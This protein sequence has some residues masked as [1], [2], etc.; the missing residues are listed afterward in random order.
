MSHPKIEA[1]LNEKE[2]AHYFSNAA[3]LYVLGVGFAYFAYKATSPFAAGLCFWFSVFLLCDSF[4]LARVCGRLERTA[5]LLLTADAGGL[6]HYASWINPERFSWKEITG[7][8]QL[9]TF[10]GETLYFQ[11][12]PRPG[13]LLRYAL[14]GAPKLD[15]PLRSVPGG[16]ESLLG[17]LSGLPEAAHLVPERGPAPGS[18][19]QA[20]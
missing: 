4:R 10:A 5:N 18:D 13:S 14:F 16:K 3:A 9:K 17:L 1:R 15:L 20:A 19:R 6:T 11:A 2:N 7:F 12:R 8:R